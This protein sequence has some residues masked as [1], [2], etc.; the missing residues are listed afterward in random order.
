MKAL[1]VVAAMGACLTG[2]QAFAAMTVLGGGQAQECFKAAQAGKSDRASLAVCTLALDTEALSPEDRGGTF[3]NRGVMEL[4]QG[5]YETAH[6]DFDEGIR[7][8]PKIGEGFANRGAMFIGER[9]Y[10]E[11]LADIDKALELGMREPAKGYFDRA[12]AYEGLDDEQSAYLDY[13]QALVLQ[14][15]WDLP[16]HELLRFTVTRR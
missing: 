5:E 3:V 4:R 8:N 16:Q 11:A 12:L 14:P 6:A 2:G 7:L 9:R 13:Q 1:F 10:K 15:G